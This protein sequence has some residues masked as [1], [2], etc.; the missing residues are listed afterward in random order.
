MVTRVDVPALDVQIVRPVAEIVLGL[1]PDQ[2]IA[3]ADPDAVS[4]TPLRRL[5]RRLIMLQGLVHVAAIDGDRG[6]EWRTEEVRI[7]RGWRRWR[8]KLNVA[9]C[10]GD[11][12][13]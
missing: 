4:R 10:K 5:V 6:R 11:I 2:L 1:P 9:P 12:C 3:V 8:R 7:G 13:H